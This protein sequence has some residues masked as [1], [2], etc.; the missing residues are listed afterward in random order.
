MSL[1]DGELAPAAAHQTFEGYEAVVRRA[2]FMASEY[3]D[4]P[5][6]SGFGYDFEPTPDWVEGI[7][8][9]G[10]IPAISNQPSKGFKP[11]ETLP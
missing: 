3:S 2:I 4:T 1:T 7:S 5:M 11:F 10:E 9:A 8:Y 6:D